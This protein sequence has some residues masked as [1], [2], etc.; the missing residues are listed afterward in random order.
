MPQVLWTLLLP[1]GLA[2]PLFK[3]PMYAFV[4]FSF[5]ILWNHLLPSPKPDPEVLLLPSKKPYLASLKPL[6]NPDTVQGEHCPTCWDELDATKAPTRLA[7][8][9]VFCNE[10]L[11]EWFKAHKNTCPVC[12]KILFKQAMFHGNDAIAEKVHKARMCLVV[13][14]LLITVLRQISCFIIRHQDPVHLSW[15]FLNPIYY[16]TGYG[17]IWS[18]INA[19]IMI[20]ADI[21]QLVSTCYGYQ[22]LGPEWFR[23]FWGHWGWYVLALNFTGSKLKDDIEACEPLT[24]M[25]WGICRWKWHGRQGSLLSWSS[26]AVIGMSKQ[27][28]DLVVEVTD[29][30]DKAGNKVI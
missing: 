30:W 19:G 7:C 25:A 12:K 11:M 9:H 29:A 2:A 22:K 15:Q 10:D 23:V 6:E 5:T 4:A 26:G 28:S 14:N 8:A 27:A 17:S 18:T 3:Y 16:L 1:I 21:A 24:R 13:V 20:F